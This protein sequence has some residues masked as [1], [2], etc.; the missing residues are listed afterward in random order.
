M[1]QKNGNWGA[2]KEAQKMRLFNEFIEDGKRMEYADIWNCLKKKQKTLPA[3][4]WLPTL[5]LPLSLSNQCL[6]ALRALDLELACRQPRPQ[7]SEEKLKPIGNMAHTA[8]LQVKTHG[9]LYLILKPVC[10]S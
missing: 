8:Q 10:S 5:W 3:D 6:T 2:H 1:A 7:S 9:H 4:K